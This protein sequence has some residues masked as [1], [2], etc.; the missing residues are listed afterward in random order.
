MRIS[1]YVAAATLIFAFTAPASFGQMASRPTTPADYN[2]IF[3]AAYGGWGEVMAG[4]LAP[5]R[6]TNPGVLQAASM[7]VPDHTQAKSGTGASC[8]GARDNAADHPGCWTARRSHHHAAHDRAGIRYRLPTRASGRSRRGDCPLSGRGAVQS[9]S[10]A[11]CLCPEVPAGTPASLRD[12]EVADDQHGVCAVARWE[13]FSGPVT[14]AC[15]W[16]QPSGD[17]FPPKHNP[18]GVLDGHA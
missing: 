13:H 9:G 17:P 16:N 4:E 7:M 12:L 18:A 6:S 5:Q 15:P 10:R 1:A 2:F 8:N 11:A 14:R 3:Q